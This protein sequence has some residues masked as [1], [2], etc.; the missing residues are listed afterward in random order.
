VRWIKNRRKAIENWFGPFLSGLIEGM[1]APAAVALI[2]WGLAEWLQLA[3]P[4]P[5]LFRDLAQIGSALFIA[6]AVATAGAASF[7]GKDL[8]LHLSWL[9]FTCG[10]GIT[11]LLALASSVGLAAYREAGHGSW[12]DILG[13]CW[14]VTGIGLL[15]LAV[16][17]LPWTTYHWSRPN[18]SSS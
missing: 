18:D 10:G 17:L 3:D 6:Y 1:A 9:G 11:G 12:Q 14:V 4:S 7:T 15:G 16:A 13:L 2:L 5:Q 8:K